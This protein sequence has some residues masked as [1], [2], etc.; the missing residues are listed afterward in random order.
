MQLFTTPDVPPERVQALRDA[1]AATM[2][3]PDFL[4]EI[5]KDKLDL[6]P[7]RGEEMQKLVADIVATPKSVVDRTNAIIGASAGASP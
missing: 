4:A 7:V 5:K 1:F 3:D 2:K 6:N